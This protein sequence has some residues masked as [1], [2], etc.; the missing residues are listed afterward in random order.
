MQ[1]QP[2]KKPINHFI[3]QHDTFQAVCTKLSSLPYAEVAQLL[4][5][6][7]GTSRAMF[8]P[9]PAAPGGKVP[10]IPNAPGD[11]KVTKP[12]GDD[13]VELGRDLGPT[14]VGYTWRADKDPDPHAV[15][16]PDVDSD[17]WFVKNDPVVDN[18]E[19]GG[20]E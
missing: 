15:Q 20:A 17:G 1:Q 2:A 13:S 16:E 5:A 3:V 14:K 7:V 8:E 12:N 19:P 18:G 11:G 10:A 9:P 4:E 6:F